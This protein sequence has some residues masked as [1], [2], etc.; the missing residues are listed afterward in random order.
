M[1]HITSTSRKRPAEQ[2]RLMKLMKNDVSVLPLIGAVRSIL[3]STGGVTI[4]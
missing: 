1:P 2:L 4:D 3:A